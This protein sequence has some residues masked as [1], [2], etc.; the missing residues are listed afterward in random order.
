MSFSGRALSVPAGARFPRPRLV[1]SRCLELDACRY[2]AVVI[3]APLVRRLESAVDLV[4]VCPELEVG[5]GVPR[6]PIRLVERA[7]EV[8]LVQPSTSRDV[9]AAMERFA[10]RFLEGVGEVDGF[11]LKARSPSCGPQDVGIYAGAH[12]EEPVRH[13]SGMFS[14]AVRARFPDVLIEDEARLADP[15]VLHLFLVRLFEAARRREGTRE[16]GASWPGGPPAEPYPR[17]LIQPE[18]THKRAT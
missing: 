9:T 2:N 13:E 18:H 10:T 6:A 15:S 5:L 1:I 8:R 4:P 17:E 11:L 16:E 3:R 12:A 7:G 14:A